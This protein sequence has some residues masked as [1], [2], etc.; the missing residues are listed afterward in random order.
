MTPASCSA[1]P[2]NAR[3]SS[4]QLAPHVVDLVAD[5]Q[6][7]VG[8]NL[9]VAA[10][11][12][13]ELAAHV[14]DPLDQRPLDVHVNVFELL[15]EGEFAGGDLVENLFQAGH[16]LV[17]LVVGED[18]HL[19]EHQGVGDR[20]AD[21]VRVK[22]PIEGH[23]L[24][25]LLDTAVRRLVKHTAPRLTG[26]SRIRRDGCGE[27]RAAAGRE[28]SSQ[29][30]YSKQLTANCQRAASTRRPKTRQPVSAP[31]AI[32]ASLCRLCERIGTTFFRGWRSSPR[33]AAGPANSCLD[34]GMMG[35]ER[36]TGG[37]QRS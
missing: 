18:A 3:C 12:G 17:P 22:P 5:P 2:T 10:A 25:E 15:A 36:H 26:Q 21:V 34:G 37:G 6:P 20:A 14:A 11:A 24:G 35:L 8:R 4:L 1:R 29:H 32:S 27:L 19:G 28:K 23:A 31:V 33:S 9:V 13:V 16:D 7:Q 30:V